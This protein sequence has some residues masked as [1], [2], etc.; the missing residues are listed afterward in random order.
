MKALL[1]LFL[2]T[3]SNPAKA[4]E[5]SGREVGNGGDAYATEFVSIARG[6]HAR[7]DELQ[8]TADVGL[9]KDRFLEAIDT[10][11][12]LSVDE[13]LLLTYGQVDAKNFPQC[14]TGSDQALCSLIL[15]NRGRWDALHADPLRKAALVLHEYLGALGMDDHRFDDFYERTGA[16]FDRLK[17]ILDQQPKIDVNFSCIVETWNKR[18]KSIELIATFDTYNSPQVEKSL[19]LPDGELSSVYWISIMKHDALF[20]AQ[21]PMATLTYTLYKTKPYQPVSSGER[22]RNG[23]LDFKNGK[24]SL[25]IS[26]SPEIQLTCFRTFDHLE[27]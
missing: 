26:H 19:P 23:K 21:V 10:T 14:K 25:R 12:V 8:L 27:R 3:I 4:T 1:I 22:L 16:I 24:R 9:D 11:R 18:N 2:L 20:L 15:F 7:W 6:M 13:P 17:A 5:G